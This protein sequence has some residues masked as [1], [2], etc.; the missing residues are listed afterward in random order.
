MSEDKPE[1]CPNCKRTNITIKERTPTFDGV[2][3]DYKCLDC[4]HE[5]RHEKKLD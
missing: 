4:K 5:W 3:T 2:I 1:K